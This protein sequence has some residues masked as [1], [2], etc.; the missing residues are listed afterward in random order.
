MRSLMY[1]PAFTVVLASLSG[2]GSVADIPSEDQADIPSEDQADIPGENQLAQDVPFI[3]TDK[4]E[5]SA[6]RGMIV[7]AGDTVW[8]LRFTIALQYTNRTDRPVYLPRCGG[9]QSPRLERLVEGHRWETVY[10]PVHLACWQTPRRVDPGQVYAYDFR[11]KAY[12]PQ[13]SVRPSWQADVVNGSYRIV[14]I[15]LIGP[16]AL[17]QSVP[18]EERSSGT[19]SVVETMP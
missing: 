4:D 1:V 2:C 9:V 12:D 16:E 6:E 8:Y 17:A 13:S 7:V 14:W 5:Y 15:V 3:T 18:L 10:E 19:F 11:I